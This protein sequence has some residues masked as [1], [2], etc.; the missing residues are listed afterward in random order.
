MPARQVLSLQVF[1]VVPPWPPWASTAA[2]EFCPFLVLFAFIFPQ[3]FRFI[4]IKYD[5]VKVKFDDIQCIKYLQ[6]V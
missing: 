3:I 4:F 2:V 1:V 6:E 5:V